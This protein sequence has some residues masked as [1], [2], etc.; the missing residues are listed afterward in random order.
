[1][2]MGWMETIRILG[3]DL[4][5]VTVFAVAGLD[6]VADA[7]ESAWSR[8]TRNAATRR[9]VRPAGNSARV[10]TSEVGRQAAPSMKSI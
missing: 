1:M 4:M 10:A 6:V 3:L 9:S 7:L 5:V 8:I 2:T